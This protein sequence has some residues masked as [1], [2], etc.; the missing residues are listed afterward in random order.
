M[1]KQQIRA[2]RREMKLRPYK[3]EAKDILHYAKWFG[4]SLL[5]TGIALV[6]A[7]I[8]CIGI[9]ATLS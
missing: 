2:F 1:N 7:W 6:G 4:F 9:W 3:R 8:T 5:V